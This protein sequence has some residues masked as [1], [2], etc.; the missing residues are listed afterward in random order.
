MQSKRE[1]IAKWFSGV[2][3]AGLLL[4][5]LMLFPQAKKSI[6][7]Y[8][9]LYTLALSVSAIA[10][11]IGRLLAGVIYAGGMPIRRSDRPVMY[12]ALIVA[13]LLF[14]LSIIRSIIKN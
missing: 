11:L 12:W 10:I 1:W 3:I 14:S 2:G 7:N 13:F 9:Q 6:N 8:Q 5:C 4:S